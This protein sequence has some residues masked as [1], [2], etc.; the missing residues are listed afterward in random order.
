M[1]RV[2]ASLDVGETTERIEITA[3]APG[4]HRRR[5]DRPHVENVEITTLPIVGRNIYTLLQLTPGVDPRQQHRVGLSGT[6]AP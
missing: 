1:A 4:E 2:D 3:A 6:C 5:P